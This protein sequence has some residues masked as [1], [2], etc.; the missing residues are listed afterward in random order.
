[1]LLHV[2]GARRRRRHIPGRPRL[3]ADQLR[4]GLA[5]ALGA[6]EV[7]R[8]GT[9]GDAAADRHRRV[10]HGPCGGSSVERMYR[11]CI[12]Y[13]FQGRRAIGADGRCA[14]RSGQET[15]AGGNDGGPCGWQRGWCRKAD[16]MFGGSTK[17]H[18]PVAGAR[19]T[20]DPWSWRR[21][22]PTRRRAGAVALVPVR[23]QGS[24]GRGGQ[25]VE[26]YASAMDV[27]R[28]QFFLCRRHTPVRWAGNRRHIRC[29][30]SFVAVRLGAVWR[31]SVYSDA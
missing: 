17:L 27:M 19:A 15:A 1:M 21:S 10:W 28:S 5:P 2:D 22:P 12:G 14:E 3:A 24:G 29:Q 16:Q 31:G 18:I 8:R 13:G 4:S 25:G 23:D 30:L 7:Y 9:G 11:G 26:T 20:T 6:T